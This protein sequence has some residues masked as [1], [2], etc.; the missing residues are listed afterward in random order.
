VLD[1]ISRGIED[2][3]KMSKVMKIDKAEVEIILNDL[4]FQ[5]L[6]IVEQKKGLFAKKMQ[7]PIMDT[8]S[9]LLYSKKQELE[10]KARVLEAMFRNGDRRGWS[11]SW[12][13]KEHGY[14]W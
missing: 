3:G 13:T 4:T 1:S 8:A 9:R 2:A 10:D 7:A 12:M 5:R 11:H 14:R 6:I